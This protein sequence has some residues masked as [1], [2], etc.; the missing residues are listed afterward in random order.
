LHLFTLNEQT[1][2]FFFAQRQ[3]DDF[4]DVH[5]VENPKTIVGAETKLP[6]RVNA[7]GI[8][9]GLR[10]RAFTTGSYCGCLSRVAR[11]NAWYF[12][13]TSFKWRWKLAV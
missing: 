1:M 13:S 9:R 10:F 6:F 11:I 2:V 7:I 8:V 4:L 5:P 3:Q 12:A